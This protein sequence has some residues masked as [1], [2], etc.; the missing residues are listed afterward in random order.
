MIHPEV[1][2]RSGKNDE[3]I[4]KLI[5]KFKN[6]MESSKILTKVKENRYFKKKSLLNR[7]RKKKLDYKNK[8]KISAKRNIK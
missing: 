6:K 4:D 5:K 2:F 3:S 1:E 8:I 7:E